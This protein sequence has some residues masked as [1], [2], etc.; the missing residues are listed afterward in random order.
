MINIGSRGFYL[1]F[2]LFDNLYIV[3]KMVRY[4][5][6][7]FRAKLRMIARRF[8]LAG[9]LLFLIYCVSTLRRTYTDESDLKVAA[10]NKMTVKQI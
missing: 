10:L 6:Q 8:Q 3:T 9:Q 7:R 2:W 4:H 5:D 1:L